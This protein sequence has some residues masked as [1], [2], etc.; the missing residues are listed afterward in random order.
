M[1]VL[2]ALA[3]MVFLLVA[4]TAAMPTDVSK[5]PDRLLRAWQNPSDPTLDSVSINTM[6][7]LRGD[8]LLLVTLM[9]P[10]GIGGLVM[11]AF[12]SGRK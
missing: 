10:A 7:Q 2:A 12:T 4:L 1:R 11:L 5:S 3:L 6:Y 9:V 8:L